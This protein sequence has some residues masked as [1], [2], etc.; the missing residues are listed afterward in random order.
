VL[1][2][3]FHG[4]NDGINNAYAYDTAT[5]RTN[6]PPLST[7]AL[8]LPTVG[9]LTEL[10]ALA[11]ANGQLFVLSGAKSTSQVFCYG[12]P[13]VSGKCA[14]VSL[15]I[16]PT[17]SQTKQ[18]FKT[19]ISHPFGIAFS[20]PSTCYISNQDTNVV[21][22][23]QLAN[24]VG[25]LGS[26][27]QSAFLKGKFPPP[28]VFLDGTFVASTVGA[29][30]E[31]AVT[32]TDVPASG[33]GLGVSI[34][35]PDPQRPDK[36]KVLNSVRDVA[37]EGGILFVCDEVAKQVNRYT[38]ANGRFLGST[39]VANSPT[40]SAIHNG[41]LWVSAGSSLY[42][43]QLP[44]PGAAASLSLQGVAITPPT[45]HKIG[46][47]SF[48]GQTVYVAFQDGTGA[49][50]IGGAIATYSVTQ[51][52]PATPPVLSN[53]QTLQSGLS[54]TPEFVLFIS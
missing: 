20:G 40:H 53:Q 29:L 30:P 1:L 46:G 22:Q 35:A 31:V 3:T 32:A 21:A 47:I 52:S 17:L 48:N 11:Y 49:N 9:S 37:V 51:D 26:G 50:A 25:S 33:G 4:G 28:S 19:A 18:H 10:R 13:N 8:A 2:V 41:G 15:V 42:W 45:G 54:D 34:G 38:I 24:N 44:P 43:G 5:T 23:V 39:P 7:D 27:C 14:F 12:L 36:V 16:G 6:A